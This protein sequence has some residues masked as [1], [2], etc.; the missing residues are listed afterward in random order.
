MLVIGTHRAAN[1]PGVRL[2]MSPPPPLPL[3]G[4]A[5][6]RPRRPAAGGEGRVPEGDAPRLWPHRA[7]AEVRSLRTLRTLRTLRWCPAAPAFLKACGAGG[8]SSVGAAWGWDPMLRPA[9]SE[10]S[11]HRTAACP[12]CPPRLSLCCR[13][14]GGSLAAFHL[15]VVKALLE[16]HM[17]PRV[18]AGSS[19][20]SVGERCAC[21]SRGSSNTL[22]G[23]GD[24]SGTPFVLNAVHSLPAPALTLPACFLLLPPPAQPAVCALVAT[25]TDAELSQLLLGGSGGG[26][27]GGG[28]EAT[29][30]GGGGGGGLEGFDLSFFSSTSP[31]QQFLANMLAKVGGDLCRCCCCCC[32]YG[33]LL[34]A[35]ADTVSMQ[36]AVHQAHAIPCRFRCVC[37]RAR[38]PTRTLRPTA[39]ATCWAT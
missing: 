20:G 27:G 28:G 21:Q 32:V 29:A 14:G 37:R 30:G 33:V 35:T 25:R 19:V 34:G 38:R 23:G 36:M 8:V 2:F 13:S 18:L 31:P 12:P 26:G 9:H 16:H 15:G 24:G 11:S 3:P 1:N 6:A 5:A 10:L 17:L 39:C 7:G 4:A 22:L